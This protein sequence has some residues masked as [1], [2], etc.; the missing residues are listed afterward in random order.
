[1]NH[2]SHLLTHDVMRQTNESP[3]KNFYLSILSESD[4]TAE[5][6]MFTSDHG[7]FHCVRFPSVR[8]VT[9]AL[10]GQ[11]GPAIW[12]RS[13]GDRNGFDPTGCKTGGCY[14]AKVRALSATR[15]RL[16]PV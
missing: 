11:S 4:K 9:T 1:M 16:S 8:G 2:E 15:R 7:P 13:D 3:R 12:R 10:S 5:H 14:S 6:E